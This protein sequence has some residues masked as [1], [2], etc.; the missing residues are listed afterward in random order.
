MTAAGQ[1]RSGAREV[2]RSGATRALARV[3]IAGRGLVWGIVGW[4]TL[5]VASGEQEQADHTGALRAIAARPLGEAA[6]TVL[7]VAFG[8]YALF[9][10]LHAAVGRPAKPDPPSRWGRRAKALAKAPLYAALS[11][12]TARVLLGGGGGGGEGT[13]SLTA[14]LMGLPGGRWLTGTAGVVLLGLGVVLALRA[15]LRRH[16]EKLDLPAVPSWLR[17]PVLAVG[18][19]GLVGRGAAVA[20]LGGLV[21]RAAV[22]FDPAQ[23]KGLDAV[24]QTVAGQPYGQALLVSAGIGMLA[25]ALWSFAEAAWADLDRG[26]V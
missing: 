9:L 23:A 11:A 22:R 20:L 8:G 5:S 6:L 24:V 15:V 13:T 16:R 4:L 26:D 19:V 25:F 10:V 3:G 17:R 12:I 7:A 2:H 14:R 21:I 1:A 18:T